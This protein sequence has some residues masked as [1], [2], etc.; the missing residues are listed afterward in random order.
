MELKN[1]RDARI[2]KYF[3]A[4]F[5]F[6]V[7][8]MVLLALRAGST[9]ALDNIR[10][11]TASM[12]SP[13]VLYLLMA[14]KEGYFKNEGLNV[15]II[16]IRGEIAA[17]IAVAGEIDFFTQALSG[18]TA[19]VRGMPLKVLMVV[20]EKP[21]W[22]FIAQ[23]QIKSFAQLKGGM[24]G[25]LSLEGSVA[26]ATR[27]ML[28]KNNLDPAKDVQLL[29]MGGNDMRFMS[30]KGKAIQ[31]TLLDAANSYR[32]QKEGFNKLAAAGDYITQYLNG[33]ICAPLEK[34]RQAPERIARF[35]SAS[36]KG[37]FFFTGRREA[38]INYMMDLLT[39]KDRDAV[40]AIY[41]STVRVM[42]RD[43]TAEDRVLASL[44]E[45]VKKSSG[46]KKE[47]RSADFFDFSFLRKAQDKLR[48]SGWR[49]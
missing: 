39:S 13:S 24:V 3:S 32:A 41:D 42:S 9:Y 21:G 45:D 33:G 20:D 6:F 44:I 23:P 36:L 10:V 2:T 5:G 16:A 38:S 17:K 40:A 18:L 25:I 48:A 11:A 19:A 46:V 35:M 12:T 4:Y 28:R 15:E 22:D 8:A 1:T 47:L 27:E 30:L 7:V 29:V 37:Y 43:G 34:I 14:Q 49:P 31:A 26:V